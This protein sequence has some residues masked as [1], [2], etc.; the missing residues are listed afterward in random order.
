MERHTWFDRT[1]YYETVPTQAVEQALYIESERMG[2]LLGALTQER[3]DTQRGVV[4]NEKRQGDNQP[5]GLTEYRQLENLFPEGHPYRHST[6]GSMADLDN[7]SL[8]DVRTWF[9][10]NYGP[11]NA[12]LVL[13]G[14][15]TSAQARALT[16][17]YFGAIPRGP[18]N[19]PAAADVPTLS[20]PIYDVMQDRV[21]NTRL[22][23]TWIVP[24]LTG[25]DQVALD[26]AAL[27]LGGLRSS[28]LDSILVRGEQTA[29][30]VTAGITAH[31]RV[32]FFEVTVDVKP[33]VD[34]AA[35]SDRLDAVIADLVANGPTADEV[36]RAATTQVS[37]SLYAV[38]Q[39]GGITEVLGNSAVLA[40]DPSFFRNN[41]ARYGEVTP[42]DV[43][44]A[45]GR[46]LTRPVYALRVDP[47][48]REP[49]EDAQS[50][51]HPP[52]D[53][54][55]P[56]ASPREPIP[57]RWRNRRS[58]FSECGARASLERRGDRLCASR[59]DPGHAA[60][61]RFR[62]RRRCRSR[63]WFRRT[64]LDARRAHRRRQWTQR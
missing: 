5:Y 49:Y 1:N 25:D 23:R 46:W 37:G 4:Q 63:Q 43:R 59:R 52:P 33:G 20:A 45:L 53:N 54:T 31:Q 62:R 12:V 18:A 29:V 40:G 47:G 22:Y 64:D 55:P 56:T 48:T 13:A 7:A 28:R 3:L 51:R 11:N 42:D 30:A 6:I 21:S 35:V 14:D 58:R 44:A 61:A 24:G 57:L 39:V 17:H 19:V 41:L 26:I 34:A 9:R 50:D 15:I 60:G 36:Q 8:E 32:S 16:Q 10:E 27:V 38:E 2:Y